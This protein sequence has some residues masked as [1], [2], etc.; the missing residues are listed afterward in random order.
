MT[1]QPRYVLGSENDNTP[2]GLSNCILEVFRK[3]W[4]SSW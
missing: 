1:P 3:D 2:T 4:I